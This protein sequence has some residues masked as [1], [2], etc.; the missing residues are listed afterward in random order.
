V[1][2]VEIQIPRNAG[3]RPRA[4][5]RALRGYISALKS[6]VIFRRHVTNGMV[7]LL[8]RTPIVRDMGNEQE[9][10]EKAVENRIDILLE[11][12]GLEKPR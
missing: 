1:L 12:L 9:F 4:A 5:L 3:R 8:S 6:S 10:G 2:A 7:S 11:S